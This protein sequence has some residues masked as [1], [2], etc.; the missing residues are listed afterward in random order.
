MWFKWPV[1]ER[2]WNCC[3]FWRRLNSTRYAF[4]NFRNATAT[5]TTNLNSKTVNS[6]SVC[7]YYVVFCR[8]FT[9]LDYVVSYSVCSLY[10]MRLSHFSAVTW[11]VRFY[12][13]LLCFYLSHTFFAHRVPPCC[14]SALKRT[15]GDNWG[16]F[17]KPR[18]HDT[19]CCQ[20]GCQTCCLTTCWMFVYTIQPVV[21]PVVQPVWQPVVSCKRGFT[22]RKSFLSPN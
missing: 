8:L 2:V 3:R 4:T 10:Y 5:K 15:L 21:K 20:T 13:L 6:K 17:L 9:L 16:V 11:T 18:L 19:T 7:S 22:G 1:V 14:A 12:W